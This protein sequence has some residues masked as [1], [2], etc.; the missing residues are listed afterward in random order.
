MWMEWFSLPKNSKFDLLVAKTQSNPSFPLKTFPII[1]CRKLLLQN[2]R[3]T[4]S[5]SAVLRLCQVNPGSLLHY[6][7]LWLEKFT[8]VN[9]HFT[10]YN[11]SRGRGCN[12]CKPNNLG[13]I[14]SANHMQ[15]GGGRGS[16]IR[17]ICKRNL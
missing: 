10:D 15:T 1:V 2:C 9:G 6:V 16:K 4:F 3:M 13:G 11:Q 5:H 7:F 12:G 8:N 17:E 14:V